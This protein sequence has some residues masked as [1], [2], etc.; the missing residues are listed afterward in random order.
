[1]RF[2]I[3]A[4]LSG[5]LAVTSLRGTGNQFDTVGYLPGATVR[6]A[7]ARAYLDTGA[8]EDEAFKRLFLRGE[9]RF[10]DLRPGG[11]GAMPLSARC[12]ADDVEGF[13]HPLLD[14]LL[15]QAAGEVLP[16][17]CPHC[18]EK[19][20]SPAGF[21]GERRRV[22]QCSTRRVAHVE[23]DA[24]SLRARG[25]R[26]HTGR[27]LE[28]GQDLQGWIHTA[29]AESRTAL[30]QLLGDGLDC[31]MGRG[32]TRGQGR[33]RLEAWGDAEADET[34]SL[35]LAR[36]RA[37]HSR[38]ARY[39]GL[40]GHA[41]LVLQ[42]DSP[43]VIFDR[44]MFSK[45]VAEPEDLGEEFAGYRVAAAFTRAVEVRGWHAAGGLP[46]RDQPAAGAGSIYLYKLATTDA[47]R[48]YKKLA[49]VLARLTASGIGERTGE[50]F[51]HVVV[52]PP[53]VA[54]AA[55]QQRGGV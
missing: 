1:M 22:V 7:L 52:A 19:L 51:G 32:R 35:I 40:S 23:I 15:A 2:L 30:V 48:E 33:V 13:E 29:T 3:N 53:F 28:A 31:Y 4:R 5:P 41:V 21:L 47:D 10:S 49:P 14:I 43:A 54:D 50:G 26:F 38:A 45:L 16:V 37:T 44:W 55:W 36:L 8:P 34:D 17:E 9:T 39:S 42:L 24:E 18:G 46:K 20:R 6:G 25:G 11:G 12:C 27:V